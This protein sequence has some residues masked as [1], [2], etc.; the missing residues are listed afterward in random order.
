VTTIESVRL[1]AEHERLVGITPRGVVDSRNC[2]VR[3]GPNQSGSVALSAEF[4]P[5]S[6]EATHIRQ[7]S[8]PEK[9]FLVIGRGFCYELVHHGQNW[10]TGLQA[11]SPRTKPDG[12]VEWSR[13]TDLLITNHCM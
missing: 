5:A 10:Y 6:Q 8:L 11:L 12:A 7:S 2:R 4:M 1:R 3:G 13:T 9:R